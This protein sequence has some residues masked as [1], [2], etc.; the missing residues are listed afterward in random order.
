MVMILSQL[1]LMKNDGK[2]DHLLMTKEELSARLDAI[3][4]HVKEQMSFFKKAL[5]SQ[6]KL[7]S[8]KLIPEIKQHAKSRQWLYFACGVGAMFFTFIILGM[9][10]T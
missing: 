1:V 3:E 8:D 5:T 2:W 7:L 4:K 9:L 6:E 10:L